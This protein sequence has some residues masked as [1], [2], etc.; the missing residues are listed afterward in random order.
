MSKDK[1][2]K[3]ALN[4]TIDPNLFNM[5]DEYCKTN[6][7][8]KNELVTLLLLK[9]FDYVNYGEDKKEVYF[10]ALFPSLNSKNAMESDTLKIPE[11]FEIYEY[12]MIKYLLRKDP[13]EAKIGN[14]Y[15]LEQ[16]PDP[17]EKN[18]II[19]TPKKIN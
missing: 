19:C 7:V 10:N 8:F 13:S 4:L 1:R 14:V 16:K 12:L 9:F 2:Y 11:L 15:V 6:N 5:L 18:K 17:N 3:R